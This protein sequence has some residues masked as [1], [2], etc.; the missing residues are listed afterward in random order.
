MKKLFFAAALL[1]LLGPTAPAGALSVSIAPLHYGTQ[2]AEGEVKKGYVDVVN[3]SAQ[4]S[5]ITLSVRAF[6]QT[7]NAGSMRFYRDEAVEAGIKLDLNEV[8]LAPGEGARVFFLLDGAALPAG[9][10]FAAILASNSP[11]SERTGVNTATSVGTLLTIE[12]GKPGPR[13]ARVTSLSAPRLQI[14]DK[15]TLSVKIENTAP[16]GSNTGFFPDIKVSL[17]PYREETV[18]GPLLFAGRERA[19]EYRTTGAYFGPLLATAGTGDSARQ[20]WTFAVTGYWRWLAPL[21][22]AVAAGGITVV[23]RLRRRRKTKSRKKL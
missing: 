11:A 8:E 5:V 15:V 17:K 20:A 9:D 12:N 2:L 6:E 19:V 23:I 21:I 1:L 22:L 18:T 4:S 10:V 16:A 7:D 3:S 13:T 14:G